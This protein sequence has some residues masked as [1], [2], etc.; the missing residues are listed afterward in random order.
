MADK[1]KMP[2]QHEFSIYQSIFMQI[3]R[4]FGFGMNKP[5]QNEPMARQF[6]REVSQ[7]V[8]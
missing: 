2:A 4:N 1:I 3:N 5:T 6:L 8:D 7:F